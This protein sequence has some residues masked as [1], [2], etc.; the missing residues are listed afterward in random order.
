MII[1]DNREHAALVRIVNE[2]MA[3]TEQFFDDY[4]QPDDHIFHSFL[5][6]SL[7]LE[8][9]KEQGLNSDH[10]YVISKE[11]AFKH[12]RLEKLE[13][14]VEDLLIRNKELRKIITDIK[15]GV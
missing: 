5:T 3:E 6:L 12:Y 15:K 8:R 4:G 9:M 10:E 1:L 13:N 7:K 2:F 11:D 14:T